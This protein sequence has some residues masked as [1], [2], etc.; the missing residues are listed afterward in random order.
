LYLGTNKNSAWNLVPE[1]IGTNWM[2]SLVHNTN[3]NA[4]P[5]TP[6]RLL[7]LSPAGGFI[8]A[9]HLAIYG[10]IALGSPFIIYYVAQFI[11]PALKRK[12]KKYLFRGFFIG[13]GLFAM[14]VCFC[15]FVL[16][17]LALRASQAYSH[18]LGIEAEQWTAEAYLSFVSKFLLGMGLGFELPVFL[19][20][21]VKLGV[22]DYQKLAGFRRYMIVINL[23]L[24]AVLTTPEILT[25]VMMAIPLQILYEI[26][27]WIAYYWEWKER[28]RQA[29][30][31]KSGND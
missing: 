2:L 15:Y 25:Q 17:P 3:E 13:M 11:L 29:A 14:G 9:F 28:K 1:Q 4:V 8:V 7:N 18:W 16:T 23:V 27:V 20:I 24:G 6:V 21:F 19:L 22:L 30:E 26:T 5:K 10:G 12:E 31:E